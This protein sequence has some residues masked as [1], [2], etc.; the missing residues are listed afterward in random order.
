M[1]RRWDGGRRE[2]RRPARGILVRIRFRFDQ[3]IEELVGLSPPS[4]PQRVRLAPSGVPD[5]LL[6]VSGPAQTNLVVGIVG[7]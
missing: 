1:T 3:E 7:I 5:A 6:A 4:S 2:G